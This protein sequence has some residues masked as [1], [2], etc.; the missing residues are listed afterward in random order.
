MAAH[1]N[2]FSGAAEESGITPGAA[3]RQTKLLEEWLG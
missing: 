1:C 3:N 2:S